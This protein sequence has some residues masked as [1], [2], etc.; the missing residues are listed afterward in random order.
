MSYLD[1]CHV[2]TGAQFGILTVIENQKTNQT[3]ENK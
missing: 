1:V 2:P 3:M